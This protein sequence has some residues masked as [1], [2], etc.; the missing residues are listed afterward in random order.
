MHSTIL[1]TE[2][3]YYEFKVEYSVLELL[4]Y[5]WCVLM[6]W[7]IYLCLQNN[8]KRKKNTKKN[9]KTLIILTDSYQEKQIHVLHLLSWK[10]SFFLSFFMN[11]QICCVTVEL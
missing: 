10:P 9:K 1:W 6:L 8:S 11:T 4:E 7:N 3:S 2:L 5:N